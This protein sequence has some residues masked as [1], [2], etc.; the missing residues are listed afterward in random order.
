MASHRR[1]LPSARVASAAALALVAL[2]APAGVAASRASSAAPVGR[3]SANL[4][5]GDTAAFKHSAGSWRGSNASLGVRG[6]VLTATARSSSA[7]SLASGTSG[8]ATAARPGVT[9]QAGVQLLSSKSQRIVTPSLVFYDRNGRVVQ[10]AAGSPGPVSARQWTPTSPVVGIAPTGAVRVL[11]LLRAQNQT[12]RT[13]LSLHRPWLMASTPPRTNVVGPLRVKGNRLYDA[14]GPLV[15]RGV[16]R[17]GFESSRSPYLMNDADAAQMKRWGANIV[18]VGLSETFWPTNLCGGRET[19]A[20]A[21]DSTVASIT[22]RGMVALLDLH[23]HA[24][25][26]CGENMQHMMADQGA[27]SFWTSVATRYMGNPLVAFDLYNEPHDISDDVWLNGGRI[28][29]HIPGNPIDITYNAVGMQQLYDTV[30][31]TGATNLVVISPKGWASWPAPPG[32]EVQGTNLMYG[33]HVYTCP[34]KDPQNG[35]SPSTLEVQKK[36]DRWH[37]F[38]KRH[39]MLLTEFGYPEP[40]DGRFMRRVIAHATAQGWGWI[41]FSWEGFTGGD[42]G[43]LAS[44]DPKKGYQ[45]NGAGMPALASLALAPRR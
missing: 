34:I 40:Q 10:E 12:A 17:A 14:R 32:M 3:F 20:Q 30:R 8:R 29:E 24:L 2:S 33:F 16:H 23:T 22:R 6:G 1:F 41:A 39:A 36:M 19:Y 21:V 42:F 37:W 31:A 13:R 44:H 11:L 15:L 28:T 35:C 45:P 38:A 5:S 7:M 26:P 27:I 25:T 43:I 9:Y 18:R 4:L